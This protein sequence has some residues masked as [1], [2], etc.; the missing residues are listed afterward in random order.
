MQDHTDLST[1]DLTGLRRGQWISAISRIGEADGFSEPL[2]RRHHGVFVERGHTLLV[3]FETLPGIEV[4]S[5]TATPLGW[6]MALDEGW[7]SLAVISSRDTWF[8]DERIYAFFDQLMDDGFF[9]EFE[10]VIF[11]GAGPC[12]YAAAA[13]SVAAP[14]ARVVILQPQ[15]T[16][17]PRVTEWDDRFAEARRVDFTSRY[18][19]APDMLDA[20]DHA[21]VLYDPRERLDAMHSA[22]FERPNVTRFRM[23]FM[24]GALQGDL[25]ELGLIGPLLT[26]A[27]SGDLGTLD[28]ARLIRARRDHTPYLR[29]LLAKLEKD[30][31]RNLAKMLCRNVSL[32]LDAPR[33]RRRLEALQAL[34]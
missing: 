4:L 30:G 9:D 13:F 12:G 20:A 27:A 22:L 16:L 14:G 18:G 26:A 34:R 33:F 15:A 17:D 10:Q 5:E 3:S 23:P 19:Y 1:V 28:F 8:R 11:Y 24:G 21:W 7:S 25:I 29:K 31:R 2:G 32:R 6:S